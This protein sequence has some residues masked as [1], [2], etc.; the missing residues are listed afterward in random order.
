[1]TEK[2]FVPPIKIQGIKTKLV[3]LIR[4]NV[5]LNADS[6]WFEPFMGSGA[7]GFN[8]APR[9]AVFAD[10]NPH[11]I[12]FYNQLKEGVITPS[13]V[14]EFLQRE[15]KLLEKNDAEHYYRVRKRF[16]RDHRSTFCF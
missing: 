5:V 16:N 4:R 9:H 8:V 14:R 7:V 1:M 2:V 12:A 3:P 15:G 6:V 13:S 10:T 11:I